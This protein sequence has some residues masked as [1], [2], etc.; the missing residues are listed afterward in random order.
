MRNSLLKDERLKAVFDMLGEAKLVLD[1]GCDHGYLS[2]ALINEGRAERVIASDISPAS[3]EKA[4]LLARGLG[5]SDRMKTVCADGLSPLEDEKA[6]YS[7]A[8][9]GMG[10][11]LIV[12]ILKK[13]NAAAKRADIIVMQPMRGEAELREYLFREGFFTVSEKVVLDDGRYYQVIAARFGEKD[14]IPEG[15]PENWF[16]FG[17]VMAEKPD[18]KLLPLLIHYRAAYEKELEKAAKKG[19]NP[20]PLTDEI[21]R[22]DALIAFVKGRIACS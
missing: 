4:G 10:G 14:T 13:G 8:I 12:K 6:P 21:E 18:E 11:E 20:K 9:S 15:F 2:A 1:V 16:R 22:T 5:I 7:I 19:K 17:W 3:C